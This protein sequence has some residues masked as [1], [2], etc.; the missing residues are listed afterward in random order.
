MVIRIHFH[1][2]R[3]NVKLVR[4]RYFFF[5]PLKQLVERIYVNVSKRRRRRNIKKKK[6]KL[7]A[8][9]FMSSFYI[10]NCVIY[11]LKI[12]W[13]STSFSEGSKSSESSSKKKFIHT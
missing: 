7:I 10:K 4:Y 12:W 5:L 2:S 1:Y 8:E 9:T 11:P 6:K 3:V 13:S